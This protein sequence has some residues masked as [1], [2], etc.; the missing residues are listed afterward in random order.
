MFFLSDTEIPVMPAAFDSSPAVRVS[1]VSCWHSTW[2]PFLP[3]ILSSR[4]RWPLAWNRPWPNGSATNLRYGLYTGRLGPKPFTVFFL[5][6]CSFI[7][8]HRFL[9]RPSARHLSRRRRSWRLSSK[10]TTWPTP[11]AS[12]SPANPY[13]T[14]SKNFRVGNNP[15]SFGIPRMVLETAC[16]NRGRPTGPEEELLGRTTKQQTRT[17]RFHYAQTNWLWC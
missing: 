8:C 9:R 5:L 1:V 13:R 6:V 12:F 2:C 17:N 14:I 15:Q 11:I 3:T 7:I 4:W 10:S 16:M